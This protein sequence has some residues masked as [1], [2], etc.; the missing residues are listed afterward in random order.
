MLLHCL[1]TCVVFDNKPVVILCPSTKCGVLL[2]LPLR[3]S[4]PLFKQHDHNFAWFSFLHGSNNWGSLNF[5]DCGFL[6]FSKFGKKIQSF[7]PN[8]MSTPP[9]A[10]SSYM[11]IVLFMLSH[12]WLE[13]FFNLVILSSFNLSLPFFIRSFSFFYF[14]FLF[15]SI[16]HFR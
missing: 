11:K 9:S 13:Y 3:V 4:L 8:F 15:S 10:D 16:F 7:L 12:R 5:L 2:W 14:Y 1:L 6:V